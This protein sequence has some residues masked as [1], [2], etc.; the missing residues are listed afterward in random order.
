MKSTFKSEDVEFLLTDMT[1]KI[2]PITLEEKKK[3]VEQG[4]YDR[5][6]LTKEF[7][8]TK[9]Y[10]DIC[11]EW[12]PIYA[13]QTAIAVGN[14]AEQLYKIKNKNLVLVSILRAGTNVGILVKRYLKN[15]YKINIPHYSMSLIKEL[16]SNSMNYLL[17][18]HRPEDIQFI[19]GWT[20]K[21]TVTKQL[22]A[23]AK[24]YE[25]VDPSLAV[26][27]DSINIAKYCGIREDI[28]IPQSPFNAC[29]TGLVSM[30][31][32]NNPFVG[33]ENFDGAIYLEELEE[34]DVSQKYLDLVEK[35]F[36]YSCNANGYTDNIEKVEEITKIAKD[37]NVNLSQLNPGI[38]EAARAILRR[39]VAKLLVKNKNDFQVKEIIELA[40]LKNIEIEEYD[41]KYYKAS[42][43]AID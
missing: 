40:K 41:F 2:E 17:S 33:K 8:V 25:G 31:I 3:R 12:T 15:K 26:L 18:K 6:I 27:S 24:K 37:Y 35:E 5:S 32:H 42:S 30:P 11:L 10:L 38:N 23:S 21:G 43:I 22:L 4:E 28:A 9:E 1:G 20:G 19:D 39:K 16:D 29:I 13:K 14:L 34:M 36:D 7:P